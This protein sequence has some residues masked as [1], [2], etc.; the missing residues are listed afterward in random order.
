MITTKI[1]AYISGV[2]L[3]A[4]GGFAATTYLKL[5][6]AEKDAVTFKSQRDSVQ[7]E[8]D[9]ALQANV[10]NLETIAALQKEKSDIAAAV[11]LLE[12]DKR[13]NQLTINK[14][15]AEIRAAATNPDNQVTL[16]P[17]LKQTIDAIQKQREER[18]GEQ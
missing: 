8:L 11:S 4:L 18:A 12:K 5:Q 13:R 3:L 14:L 9:K 16:S 2:A 6:K 15:S 7:A 1:I 10:V 17:V